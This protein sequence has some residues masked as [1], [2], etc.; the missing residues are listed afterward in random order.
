MPSHD[1][2]HGLPEQGS[3]RHVISP[4]VHPANVGIYVQYWCTTTMLSKGLV[5]V[6]RSSM[7]QNVHLNGGD[8]LVTMS[9][10]VIEQNESWED[11]EVLCCRRLPR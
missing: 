4:S 7:E 10:K 3:S 6:C 9:L 5:S 2:M 11:E 1:D 8:H